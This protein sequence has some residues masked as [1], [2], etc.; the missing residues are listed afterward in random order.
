MLKVN[1]TFAKCGAVKQ[2]ILLHVLENFDFILEFFEQQTD[3]ISIQFLKLN[4]SQ[5]L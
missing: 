5:Q 4:K 2:R 3:L 1:E